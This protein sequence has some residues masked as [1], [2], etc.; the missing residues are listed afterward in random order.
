MKKLLP[1]L[2]GLALLAVVLIFALKNKSGPKEINPDDIASIEAPP[3]GSEALYSV[4]VVASQKSGQQESPLVELEGT[5]AQSEQG[6][7]EF[8]SHWREI[9]KISLM[10]APTQPAASDA[11]LNK[12]MITT[13]DGRDMVHYID[14][15]FPQG[16]LTFQLSLLQ[17]IFL[18]VKPEL[19]K[20]ILRSEKDEV[21][22]AKVQ[23]AFTNE[24]KNFRAVKTW[25]QYV[26]DYIKV[27]AEDNNLVYAVGPDGRLISVEGTITLHYRQPASTH[28]TTYIK[29]MLKDHKPLAASAP[30]VAK[31]NLK[32][33]DIVKAA[34]EAR[35]AQD[36]SQMTYEEALQKLDAITE[37]T[38]SK[39][40]YAVFSA[41][42]A[43]VITNPDHASTLVTKILAEKSRDGSA[44][45][46]L[47]AMFGAL[48]Q[49]Q[50]GEIAN[51]LANLATECP[52]NFCKVQA[53]VGLN[54]HPNPSEANAAKMMEIAKA[55]SDSEISGTALLAAGSIGKKLSSTLPELPR[56]LIAELSDPARKNMQSTVIAA[57]G[58]H[59]AADYYP[60]L[61]ANLSNKDS[62]VRSSAVY[63]MRYLPNEEVNGA[64]I[65]VILKETDKDVTREAFK[66]LQYRN[67]K[68]EQYVSVA[69]KTAT[70]EDM[71]LQQNAARML[72]EAYHDNPKNAEA[73]LNALKEKTKFPEVKAYIES[74]MKAEPPT[75]D[76]NP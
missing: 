65:N 5:L 21:G 25:L 57:M 59:G 13:I 33:T 66:A 70:M 49:S 47:S 41:L 50:S 19:G 74:E 62:N 20:S 63:S 11:F 17:K 56:E 45:R 12:A 71:D 38:D 75:A 3:A 69:E 9:S 31:D 68:D 44:R 60:T 73:S 14:P 6:A 76:V 55:N 2:L 8:I 53:I 10:G 48:A 64:L 4:K 1:A 23:Y 16:L 27:D 42:K 72:I 15:S 37:A 46:R 40:V 32:K 29:V 39:E 24:G 7:N 52:D 35:Q 67:L 54:D 22:T 51:S 34:A 36:Q 26:Q 58:N 28:F 43:D 61:S 30:K 18:G